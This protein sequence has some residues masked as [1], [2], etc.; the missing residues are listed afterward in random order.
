MIEKKRI[1]YLILKTNLEKESI[2]KAL[3]NN[4]RE[5]NNISIKRI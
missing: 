5:I 4:N 2:A 1:E 3:K